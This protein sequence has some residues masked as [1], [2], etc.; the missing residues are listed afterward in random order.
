MNPRTTA[1]VFVVAALLGAFV[2]FYEIR[3][4][5]S[6]REAEEA[7]KR[8]FPGVEQSDVELIAF[9]TSDGKD[10]V[11]ERGDSGWRLSAPITFPADEFSA[12][13]MA[14]AL[15]QVA[16]E[17][18]VEEPRAPEVYGLG[19]GAQEIRFTAAG[20]QQ[21]LR[22]GDQTPVGGNH[23]AAVAGSQAVYVVPSW[24]AQ[25]FEKSLEDLREKRILRFDSEAVSVVR[26][27][28][29]TGGVVLEK[30]DG[31][32]RLTEPTQADADP[33]TV[34][35][36][37]SDL[38]FLRAEGF[39][40][41]PPADAEA[42]LEEPDFEV[43]LGMR[44]APVVRMSVGAVVDG[45]RL[46]RV[47]DQRTLYRVPAERAKDFPRDVNAYRFR[48]LAAFEPGDAARLEIEFRPPDGEGLTLTAT[49]GDDGW[50]AEP[51]AFQAGKL[52]SLVSEL[53]HLEARRVLE[54]SAG[55]E[56][57]RELAL[58]PPR[59]TYRAIDAGGETLAE[60]RMGT[61]QGGEG[62]VATTAGRP[63]VFVLEYELGEHL[64][65]SL[66]AF[67]NRFAKGD[68]DEAA[69]QAPADAAPS[70]NELPTEAGSP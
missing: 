59:A 66:E 50:R 30:Q 19:D 46:V 69:A 10:A 26:A 68:E 37:L 15:A 3:G 32:W 7:A 64:P 60:V 54:D 61:L 51:E 17:A 9:R 5:E 40:D 42:G 20:T 29:P 52:D 45:S 70:D 4:G 55:E 11:I 21:L 16:S 24:R 25:S 44:G 34:E 31:S 14:G 53:S 28:W 22:L 12:D 58:A 36:L 6:R 35:D 56:R 13:G 33:Q 63:E 49:R 48:Q 47:P 67:R 27:R 1:I 65:V 18:V 41:E 43:E 39:V 57:L 62:I 23:Y 8:L 38:S 2:Y